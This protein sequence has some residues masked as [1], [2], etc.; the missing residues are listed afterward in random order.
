MNRFDSIRLSHHIGRPVALGALALLASA[1]PTQARGKHNSARNIIFIMTDQQTASAMSCAGNPYV[2]TPAM[3]ALAE[4]GVR[5]ERA[6]CPF[7]LSG[8]SRAS[9]LTGCTA[10]EVGAF[11]NGIRPHEADMELGLG[12]R[13]TEAG[14]ESLYAGKWHIPEVNLPEEGTGFKR[15]CVMDDR[16]LADACADALAERD[17]SKPLFLVA[18]L[19]NPHEI[20]EFARDQSLHYGE[21]PPFETADCP[22]LPANFRP[23]TYEAEAIRLE[24]H[25]AP[26]SHDIFNYTE[27]DWRRYLYGYYRLVERVDREIGRLVE[28]LKR[29]GIYD[30][31][32]IIF[33]SDHGDGCAAHEWNQKWVLFEEVINVPLIVK[34]PKGDGLRGEE[35]CEALSNIGLDI[36]RTIC[37]YARIELPEERYRGRS[38]RP[39]LEGKSERLHDE[40]FVETLLSSV[41][42]RG[43]T[44]V[45][46]RYKYVLYQ[47]Y[48]N[49]EMLHDLSADPGEMVNLAVDKRYRE[50]LQRLRQKMYDWA[51]K[52][53][54]KRLARE[55]KW[56]TENPNTPTGHVRGNR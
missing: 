36:Y 53:G 9:L 20:C 37:D 22:N 19:L 18:S 7:P 4:D 1:T 5:F 8:P 46:G 33:T 35:N 24:E 29:E 6:Y 40:V 28:V 25:M 43:W 2:E 45:E 52:T 42:T 26:R 44:I 31:S 49:R 32:L 14:Y 39:I 51:L 56:L 47:T 27:D 15:V 11:D 3:D 54:D 48:Q 10:F 23:S 13:L 12:H 55:L 16:I 34:A 21:L 38:Y 30:N 41:G 17:K 50:E